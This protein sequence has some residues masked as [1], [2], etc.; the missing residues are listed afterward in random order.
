MK[1]TDLSLLDIGSSIQIAGAI[2]A[3]ADR[4]YLIP[5]PDGFDDAAR[6]RLGD[7]EG[8]EV[9]DLSLDDWET[10][11]RQTDLLETEVL[12]K[13]GPNEAPVKVI[14]RKST[15][16]VDQVISWRCFRRDSY[17]CCYCGA[18]DLPLTVDHL[19]TWEEGGPTEMANLLSSCRKCNK[20]RGNTPYS[21]WLASP[22]YR[23]ASRGLSLERCRRNAELVP[24]LGK[25]QRRLH[26]VKR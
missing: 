18:D 23:A 19:V 26:V 5:L 9:L 2:Y 20:V 15:R 24:T 7:I 22:Y 25:I 1:L 4:I 13:A 11:H 3:D 6:A 10:F 21:E 17:T 8:V 14:L 12:A 16:Q